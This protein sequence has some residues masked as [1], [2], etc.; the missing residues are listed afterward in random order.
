MME[1][2]VP[3]PWVPMI[4]FVDFARE[5]GVKR[6]VLCAGTTAAIGKDG[7]GRV[8]EHYVRNDLD[9]CVLRPPWF[10]GTYCWR[11]GE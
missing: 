1:P 3:Q 5:R 10:M 6:Y 8:W 7:M 4:K 11:G 2:Q 9:F